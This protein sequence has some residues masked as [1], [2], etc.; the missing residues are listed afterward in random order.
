[1][2]T[3][4]PAGHHGRLRIARDLTGPVGEPAR[5][6]QNARVVEDVPVLGDIAVRQA[7]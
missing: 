4:E 3:L 2:H 6:V 5:D 7:R 1:V